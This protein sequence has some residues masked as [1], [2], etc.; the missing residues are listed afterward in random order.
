MPGGKFFS[1]IDELAA[2]ERRL[3]EAAEPLF[4]EME[5]TERQATEAVEARRAKLAAARDYI[6]RMRK[7]TDAMNKSDEGDNGGPKLPGSGEVP[8]PSVT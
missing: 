6:D 5:E 1:L 8:K 2:S 4:K 3:D 7:A